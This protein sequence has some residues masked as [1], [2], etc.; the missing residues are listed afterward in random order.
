VKL[1]GKA[2]LHTRLNVNS[3]GVKE[4]TM[5]SGPLE[6][7]GNHSAR[8][9]K[10][11]PGRH[12]IKVDYKYEGDEN[13]ALTEFTDSHY[14]QSM[15]AFQLPDKTKI[16]NFAVNQPI[17]LDTGSG[18]KPMGIAATLTLDKKKTVLFLYNVNVKTDGGH[19]AVRLRMGN[20]YNRKS[21]MSVKDLTYGRAFAYVVRVLKKGAY[22]FDLD[23]SSSS[24]NQFNPETSDASVASLQIVE[25]D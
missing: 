5:S 9:I 4:T 18:Y 12:M 23:Y 7:V 22:T 15:V 1:N 24:K 2:T 10:L 25:L 13:L 21:V 8:V 16:T 17:S 19:F 3:K 14:T 20:A 6:Y 11:N